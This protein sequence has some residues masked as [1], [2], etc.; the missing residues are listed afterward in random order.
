YKEAQ[1]FDTFRSIPEGA[2]PFML[3]S[4]GTGICFVGTPVDHHTRRSLEIA[5]PNRSTQA[6]HVILATDGSGTKRQ[7]CLARW[8]AVVWVGRRVSCARVSMGF[9]VIRPEAWKESLQHVVNLQ[10]GT[11][12][13]K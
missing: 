5:T 4:M 11:I 7:S 12:R 8:C 6:R 2:K 1:W 10:F 3:K 13:G 9:F